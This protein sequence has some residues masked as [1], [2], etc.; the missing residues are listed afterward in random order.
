MW[1]WMRTMK[2]NLR[3]PLPASPHA[4]PSKRAGGQTCRVRPLYLLCLALLLYL[5]LWHRLVQWNGEEEGEGEVEEEGLITLHPVRSNT[6]VFV[7]LGSYVL[8]GKELVVLGVGD[9]TPQA[10]PARDAELGK[11]PQVPRDLECVFSNGQRV[12]A[13]AGVNGTAYQ[14]QVSPTR[15]SLYF[16]ERLLW[17]TCPL[18][19]ATTATT[20][21]VSLQANRGEFHSGFTQPTVLL[22]PTTHKPRFALTMCTSAVYGL[23]GSKWITEW[24]EHH[25]ANGFDSV[26]LYVHTVGPL[27]W[28]VLDYY[29]DNNSP[30]FH[31]RVVN[32][33]SVFDE[34]RVDVGVGRGVSVEAWEHGQRLTRN[35]CYLRNRG[36]SRWV[37]FSDVD[38]LFSSP[39]STVRDVV[40]D[41]CERAYSQDPTK[42]ACSFSSVTVPPNAPLPDNPAKLLLERLRESESQCQPPYNCGRYHRGREKYAIRTQ[43]DTANLRTP[44][45]Y[46]AVSRDYVLA[47]RVHVLVPSSLGV[48]RHYAGHFAHSRKGGLLRPKEN[49]PPG[50]ILRAIQRELHARPA[51]LALYQQHPQSE[52]FLRLDRVTDLWRFAKHGERP[53]PTST[54]T[55]YLTFDY[56]KGRLNNQLWTLDW[57]MRLALSLNRTAVLGR[58]TD[59]EHFVGLPSSPTDQSL[60]DV[61]LL[62]QA[63]FRFLFYWEVGEEDRD[64][65]SPPPEADG[66][67][68]GQGCVW[69]YSEAEKYVARWAH[70]LDGECGRRM[71]IASG[72][73]LIHSY[74]ADTRA[75]GGGGQDPLVFWR[76]M[77]PHPS[78]SHLVHT[79]RQQQSGDATRESLGLHW[80]SWR[81]AS[82]T[83]AHAT[84][85]CKRLSDKIVLYASKHTKTVGCA[86]PAAPPP[87]PNPAELWASE[88]WFDLTCRPASAQN[89]LA[90]TRLDPRRQDLFVATDHETAEADE[91]F[92]SLGARMISGLDAGPIAGRFELATDQRYAK[93]LLPILFDLELMA[94][95]DRFV[96]SPASTLSHAVC[97]WRR[98]RGKP[99]QTPG[100]C[101]LVWW[102]T[103]SDLCEERV[104]LPF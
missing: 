30:R 25:R 93:A 35:D 63:P 52:A 43:A 33:T 72:S 99:E 12:A 65:L 16:G 59:R 11:C 95:V 78:V 36:R 64:L 98:A 88:R 96:G 57:V 67:G 15:G 92:V 6:G 61:A 7:T 58:P 22:T 94:Q 82:G 70:R 104:C 1:L 10:Q 73:G 51:L 66:Q 87:P 8:E 68:Q 74:K 27:V 34:F 46:H 101:Q 56:F 53:P 60:W 37:M 3:A 103:F 75:Y 26:D 86:C 71:H 55:Q 41:V 81:E 76:H 84:K 9:F 91:V 39:T 20:S 28:R 97:L 23:T 90:Y 40:N 69:R 50:H 100:M 89:I 13:V 44:L 83:E 17:I 31:V 2:R 49:P 48:V 32:W 85:V 102:S 62:K 18:P 14:C 4:A 47:D 21:E 80:R 79:W 45:F 42:M 5:L 77:R 19:A 38:E 29:V 54:T 24:L